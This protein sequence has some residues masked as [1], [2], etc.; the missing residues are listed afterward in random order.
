MYSS[1]K[2]NIVSDC[3]VN[4]VD[5]SFLVDIIFISFLEIIHSNEK[6]QKVR[7]NSHDNFYFVR[8]ILKETSTVEMS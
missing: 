2:A 6:S 7:E 8:I 1:L 4:W 5:R 3:G